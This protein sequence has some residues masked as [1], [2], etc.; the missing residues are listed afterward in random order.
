[1]SAASEDID[2]NG[3]YTVEDRFGVALDRS[4]VLPL[5]AGCNSFMSSKDEYG[6][7]VM[8]CFTDEKFYDAFKLISDSLYTKNNYVY[9]TVKNEADGV[10]PATHF[11]SEYSLFYISTVGSLANLRTVE[12]EFAV[13]PMPKYTESQKNYVSYIS[14]ENASAIGVMATGRNLR[15]T[16]NILE[17]LA[18]ESHRK[19]GLRDCYVDTVLAFK[20][21]N[22]EKSRENLTTILS[23]GVLDPCEIYG[24]GGV[25]NKLIDLAGDSDTYSSTMASVRLKSLSDINDTIEEVNNH[26]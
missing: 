8:T 15:K 16:G 5:V 25:A 20:Y 19:N 22:H 4:S 7:P 11:K 12:F 9:D 17:N 10:S 3:K 21:L 2:G 13:L 6:L 1:M 26:K 14:G 23:T 18:A 24:W